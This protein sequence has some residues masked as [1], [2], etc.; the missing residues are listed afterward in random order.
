MNKG[1]LSTGI[2]GTVYGRV[3]VYSSVNT[4]RKDTDHKQTRRRRRRR[5]RTFIQERLLNCTQLETRTLTEIAD[6][7]D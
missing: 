7:Q 4:F 5:R 1:T 6:L 3:R 2:F